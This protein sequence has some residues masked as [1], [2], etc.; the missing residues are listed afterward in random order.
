MSYTVA[1]L[2]LLLLLLRFALLLLLLLL[3][4]QCRHK[5]QHLLAARHLQLV[6][7]ILLAA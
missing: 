6:L 1:A 7:L 3:D 2:L 5:L 4:H